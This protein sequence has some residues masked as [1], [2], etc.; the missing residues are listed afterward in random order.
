MT[1]IFGGA[2]QGKLDY[3]LERFGL[4]VG[5]VCRCSS[6]DISTPTGKIVYEIDR[7]ILALI[8]EDANI[9]ESVNNFIASGKDAIVI[10]NDISCGI[11]PT[12][13]VLRKWREETGRAMA[14]LARH[15]DE[16]VRL[17]CGIPS[18]VK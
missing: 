3:A 12:D 1:L 6:E 4:S 13:A 10:C 17:F 16:V 9:A 8:K 11:V 5:D 2:Y 18:V 15:A 14:V 7:W